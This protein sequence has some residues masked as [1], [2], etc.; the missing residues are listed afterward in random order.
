[1]LWY[2]AVKEY[3]YTQESG[4]YTTYGIMVYRIGLNG[5]RRCLTVPDVSLDCT[6]VRKLS[7]DCTR[8]QLYPAQ[9]YDVI[10]DRI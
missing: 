1:M 6:L 9:L 5:V 10:E 2:K 8:G 7:W 3:A 4:A